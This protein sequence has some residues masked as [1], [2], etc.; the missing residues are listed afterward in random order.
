[1]KAREVES[2]LSKKLLEET[3]QEE[4]EKINIEM[5]AVTKTALHNFIK[6]LELKGEAWENNF[7]NIIQISI[8]VDDYRKLKKQCEEMEK[9]QHGKTWD[10]A[11][12]SHE[13]RGHVKSR[14]ICDFDEYWGNNFD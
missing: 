3:T 13:Q 14:S 4:L 1:M 2:E 6:Q 10:N 9:E 5:S 7:T 11:I 12:E 8:D